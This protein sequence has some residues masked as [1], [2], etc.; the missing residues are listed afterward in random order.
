[1]TST[2]TATTTATITNNNNYKQ[3]ATAEKKMNENPQQSELQQQ[4]QQV[5]SKVKQKVY[6][7]SMSWFLPKQKLPAPPFNPLPAL[8]CSFSL[9]LGAALWVSV[10]LSRSH[11]S[12]PLLRTCSTSPQSYQIFHPLPNS[13][14]YAH[15]SQ[16]S[17]VLAKN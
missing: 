13:K 10:L 1:M 6:L 9:S 7:M 17:S 11:N 16:R 12:S 5:E 15:S 4:Q 3:A 8:Y 14:N 2:T